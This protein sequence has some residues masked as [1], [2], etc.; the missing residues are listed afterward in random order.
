M[1][2]PIAI[3]WFRRDLRLHDNHGLY[4]ALQ[5]GLPVLPLFIFD[6]TILSRLEEKADRR[7]N[8]IHERL[9]QL[10]QELM[11]VGSGLQCLYG[12][13]ENVWKDLLL[14]YTVQE[15][16]CNHDYEPEAIQRDDAI[17]NI[18]QSHQIPFHTFKDQVVF[19]KEEILKPDGKPYTVFTPYSR[20]WKY[21]LQ[22][23]GSV[24]EYP[25]EQFTHHFLKRKPGAF[26]SLDSIGFKKSPSTLGKPILASTILEHYAEERNYPALLGTTRLGP[27]LRFGTISIR[28]CVRKA[29]DHEVWLNEL[30]W[31]EFFMM[32]LYHFPYVVQ[33]AFKPKYNHIPWRQDEA[34][35]KLWCEGR[36]GYDM[37]DAGMKELNTTGFMHNRV[38]MITA[39]FLTKHLL[40]DWRWGE[41]YFASKLLD[42]DLSAN[43]GNWQWAA[44]CGC[45]AAPYFRIF[46]PMEQAKKF[47]AEGMYRKTWLPSWPLQQELPIVEHTFAR[48]R[49]LDVYKKAL[50]E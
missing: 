36:T 43:N 2:E 48:Q 4:Q 44:G 32:I 33:G 24:P 7:V 47:D 16:Y 8:F 18:L 23:N 22:K 6:E 11:Q 20:T 14:R 15:V 46:N 50:S 27:H 49:A 21:T 3:F 19:E 35:F 9:E 31:R 1:F 25:S 29:S 40:I 34:Q 38:R 13:P 45:D 17:R 41:A 42:Y 30:I 12:K 28:D 37:V 5:S 10:N 39:S 26:I